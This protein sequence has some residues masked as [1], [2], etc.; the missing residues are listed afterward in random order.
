MGAGDL[1]SGEK[2][3]WR[4]AFGNVLSDVLLTGN[5]TGVITESACVCGGAGGMMGRWRTG[6][7]ASFKCEAVVRV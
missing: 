4:E 7:R 2:L 1:Y 5:R 6:T 3:G